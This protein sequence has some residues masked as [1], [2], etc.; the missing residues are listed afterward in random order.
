MIADDPGSPACDCTSTLGAFPANAAT[1]FI[2]LLRWI[3]VESTLFRTLPSFSAADTV[4]APVTT[5][6]PSC[7]GLAASVKSCVTP[8]GVSVICTV[9]GLYPSRRAVTATA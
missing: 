7:M 4:P 8:P 1:M 5:T 2:S 9:I 6:S 3:S